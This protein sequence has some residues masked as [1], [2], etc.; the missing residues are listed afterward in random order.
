MESILPIYFG[1]K[2]IGN[3]IS[4]HDQVISVIWDDHIYKKLLVGTTRLES[5]HKKEFI[6]L[7]L[8]WTSKDIEEIGV[9]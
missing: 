2:E 8:R 9:Q 7:D 3:I 5:L 6:D 4:S 1:N